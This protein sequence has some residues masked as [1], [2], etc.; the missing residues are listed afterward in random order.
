M[1]TQQKG[2]RVRDLKSAEKPVKLADLMNNYH[3]GYYLLLVASIG[4]EDIKHIQELEI[5]MQEWVRREVNYKIPISKEI[6]SI[7]NNSLALH[8]HGDYFRQEK[9]TG[10]YL[11][12]LVINENRQRLSKE[13]PKTF[14]MDPREIQKKYFSKVMR[15][16]RTIK[17]EAYINRPVH[18][19]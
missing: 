9:S 15:D 5:E 12:N 14:L 19:K 7:L 13:W 11:A 10:Y 6:L 1:R 2:E 17:E 8:L 16:L 18:K 4:R 3:T